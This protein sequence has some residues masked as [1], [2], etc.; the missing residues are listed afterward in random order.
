[1]PRIVKHAVLMADH[2]QYK[3]F[4][5]PHCVKILRSIKISEEFPASSFIEEM[6][7][8]I[9]E[10]ILKKLEEIASNYCS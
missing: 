2:I 1:M 9:F 7:V 5:M 8:L 4:Q 6:A 10:K 3:I